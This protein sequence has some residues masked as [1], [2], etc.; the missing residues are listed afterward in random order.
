MIGELIL[1][2]RYCIDSYL[3]YYWLGCE[4]SLNGIYTSSNNKWMWVST[5]SYIKW[6]HQ[7]SLKEKKNWIILIIIGRGRLSRPAQNAASELTWLE[8]NW[9]GLWDWVVGSRWAIFTPSPPSQFPSLYPLRFLS[10]LLERDTHTDNSTYPS[11]LMNILWGKSQNFLSIQTQRQCLTRCSTRRKS[12][13]WTPT[14][15]PTP[16]PPSPPCRFFPNSSRSTTSSA[17][18]SWRLGHRRPPPRWRVIPHPS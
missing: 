10:L 11:S 3:I 6:V 17:A 1:Y 4:S 18:V 9:L 5:I 13:Q 14:S 7:V 16:Y 8:Y 2:M 12:C 15:A